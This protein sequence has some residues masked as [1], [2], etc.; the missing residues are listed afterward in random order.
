MRYFTQLILLTLT[1]ILFCLNAHAQTGYG[2]RI[3]PNFTDY[4]IQVPDSLQIT[5]AK[6]TGIQ[7]G[8]FYNI[9]SGGAFSIQPEVNF[10][11]KGIRFNEPNDIMVKRNFNYLEL[12][13]LGKTTIGGEN[14]KAFLHLGPGISYLIS[15]QDK[16]DISGT[17]KVDL[18]AENIRRWD[19]VIH[20]GLGA[21]FRLGFENALFIE[22]RY[23]LSISDLNNVDTSQQS[24]DY[25]PVNHRVIGFTIG[26]IYYLDGFEG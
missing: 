14:I 4:T 2:F 24:D 23:S 1:T 22:G 13:V 19:T 20:A 26:Y 21:A 12:N 9:S 17:T 25:K 16:T 6:K 10:S 8:V 18:E 3:G 7:A 11:Q 5:P 15:A